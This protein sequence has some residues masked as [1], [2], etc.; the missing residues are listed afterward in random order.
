MNC[1][2]C[3]YYYS[4]L[5]LEKAVSKATSHTNALTTKPNLSYLA[6]EATQRDINH[7]RAALGQQQI[8]SLL[9][10]VVW[11]VD[12]VQKHGSVIC[13]MSPEL[14]R[15]AHGTENLENKLLWEGF[16][17]AGNDSSQCL[18]GALIMARAQQDVKVAVGLIYLT[19]ET[20][21]IIE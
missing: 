19:R 5:E 2:C 16:K 11:H 3:Y 18:Q 15:V 8:S 14:L 1:A 20:F 9:L 12:L 21:R 13:K 17:K 10:L 4:K 7:K 6:G